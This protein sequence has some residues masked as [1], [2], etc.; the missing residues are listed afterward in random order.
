MTPPQ[1]IGGDS[2]RV[3]P[4]FALACAITWALDLPF[5]LAVLRGDAPAPSALAMAGLGAWGPTIAAVA[6]AARGRRREIF[7]PWRTSPRWIVLALFTPL[8]LHL[9]ATALDVAL[10]GSP[11][12]WLYLPSAPEHVAALV[13]FSLGEEFGWRGYAYPR[14]AARHGKVAGALMLGVVWAFWHFFMM[15]S[16]VDGSFDAL[17]AT[18]TLIELPLYSILF[19]WF[20][21]RSGASIAVAIAL[22][23]GGHL[24]NVGRT[25]DGELR[26]RVLRIVVLAIAA[27]LAARSL[28]RA[29]SEPVRP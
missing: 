15:F 4:F 17:L 9:P 8:L 13:M 23:A 3:Y 18:T 21:V 10:G 16:P 14:V 28:E 7:G 5:V 22:H 26:I 2:R 6:V 25:P 20:F 12:Q 1:S 11:S 27:A 24:D 29:R 19:A